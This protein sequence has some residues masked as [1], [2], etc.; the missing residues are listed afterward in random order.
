MEVCHF[1]VV[2]I[3]S[4]SLCA[5]IAHVY[6]P[7]AVCILFNPSSSCTNLGGSISA[8][9]CDPST[10]TPPC[11]LASFVNSGGNTPSLH[12]IWIPFN[13]SGTTSPFLSHFDIRH[14]TFLRPFSL[15]SISNGLTNARHCRKCPS[16]TVPL[17][18]STSGYPRERYDSIPRLNRL[19]IFFTLYF[20]R[21]LFSHII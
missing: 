19:T 7:H 17:I 20:L 4:I 2:D 16:H 15:T 11:S 12:F 13:T 18:P 3:I 6:I 9:F 8:H 21:R 1:Q 5:D 14:P 10:Y